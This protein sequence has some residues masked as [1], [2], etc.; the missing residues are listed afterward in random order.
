MDAILSIDLEYWY[1]RKLFKDKIKINH[2]K[3]NIYLKK[4][5]DHLLKLFKKDKKKPLFSY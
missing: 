3:N 4:Q 1:D 2:K 5:V